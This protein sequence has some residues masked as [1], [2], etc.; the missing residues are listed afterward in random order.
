VVKV[1][2]AVGSIINEQP[3]FR[4]V[5]ATGFVRGLWHLECML[6]LPET[7]GTVR[8][9]KFTGDSEEDLNRFETWSWRVKYI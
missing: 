7:V 2:D 1:E 3:F 9:L 8:L 4:Q 6:W 5:F